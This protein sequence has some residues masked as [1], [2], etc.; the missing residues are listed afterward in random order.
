MPEDVET[1]ISTQTVPQQDPSKVKIYD[2]ETTNDHITNT[3]D[4]SLYDIE[5]TND[6]QTHTR[7]TS[8]YE[9]EPTNDRRTHTQN[10][11]RVI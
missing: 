8:L 6:H 3:Q 5:T 2:V 4:N 9:D 11:S 7:N 1:T 10:N